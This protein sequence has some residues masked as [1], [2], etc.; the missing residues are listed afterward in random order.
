MSA[1]KRFDKQDAYITTYISHKK[2][3][4]RG[5]EFENLGIR[6][7]TNISGDRL[8][9]LKHLYYPEKTLTTVEN[10]ST[11]ETVDFLEVPLNYSDYFYQTTLYNN[12]VRN[13]REGAFEIILP[14]SV[15]GTYIKPGI[16]LK[17]IIENPTEIFYVLPGYWQDDYTNDIS[18]LV[19][20][21]QLDILD[22]G[23]GGL[24]VIENDE[25]RYIGDI[26]YT[27]GRVII[28]DL[29]Y[30][31]F[32][33]Q[34]WDPG[35]LF[36]DIIGG[37]DNGV[38][39]PST[40]FNFRLEWQSSIPIFTYNYKCKLR[41]FEY[42]YTYNPTT[43]E[44]ELE[45]LYNSDNTVESFFEEVVKGNIK[46]NLLIDEFSPYITSV[47]LYSDTNELIAVGKLSTPVPKSKQ[48]EMTIIVKLDI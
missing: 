11:Q 45:E 20:E 46:Q 30:A 36:D 40:R 27:H 12:S 17:F 14:S 31:T 21:V 9:Q 24:Y 7:N 33:N 44:R 4:V 34:G 18:G 28:T 2:W 26:I 32:L 39:V 43:Q 47:G 3:D 42:N 38:D 5:N 10:I 16:G 41:E 37:I 25:R 15:Y 1:F 6:V 8:Q 29:K 22:D 13:L 23:E 19:E 35:I 48:T